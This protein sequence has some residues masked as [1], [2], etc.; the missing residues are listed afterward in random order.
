[1]NSR[2]KHVARNIPR[3]RLLREYDRHVEILGDDAGDAD[4]GRLDGE[5]PGYIHSCEPA[6][7]FLANLVE[8][9]DIHLV[10]QERPHLENIARK[11]LSVLPYPVD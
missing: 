11:D 8:Q 6:C 4:T 1:M 3:F 9:R 5:D 7:E 2:H 10:V